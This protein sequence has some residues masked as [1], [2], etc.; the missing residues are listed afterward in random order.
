VT[1]ELNTLLT[2]SQSSNPDS[3]HHSDQT[4][5]FSAGRWVTSRFCEED[6]LSSSA[7]RIVRVRS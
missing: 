4:R 7:L 6:I 5:L 2:Y 1:N 3:P